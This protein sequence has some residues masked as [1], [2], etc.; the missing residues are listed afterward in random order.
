M[1]AVIKETGELRASTKR[2]A[3]EAGR[4]EKVQ[5]WESRVKLRSKIE[6]TVA[7]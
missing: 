6:R 3:N 7:A 1:E 4:K 5:V 2:I